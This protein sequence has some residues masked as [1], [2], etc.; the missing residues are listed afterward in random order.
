MKPLDAADPTQ[1]GG[2]TLSGR[3]HARSKVAGSAIC[4][5]AI[6][7]GSADDL[8]RSLWFSQNIPSGKLAEGQ[9]RGDRESEKWQVTGYGAPA[10][11]AEL[12][13]SAPRSRDNGVVRD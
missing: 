2:I 13:T 8:T 3:R 12:A 11:I 10:D 6:N 4:C 7:Q 9:S 5:P 1:L